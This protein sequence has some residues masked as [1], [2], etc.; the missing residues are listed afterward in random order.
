MKKI[1]DCET[2]YS[3]AFRK[4]NA[5]YIREYKIQNNGISY[6]R[7]LAC[8]YCYVVVGNVD[9][10]NEVLVA[11]QHEAPC[12]QICVGSATKYLKDHAPY[13]QHTGSATCALCKPRPCPRCNGSKTVS[14]EV[15]GFYYGAPIKIPATTGCT[16]CKATGQI[17]GFQD[18]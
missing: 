3:R 11:D 6:N 14:C 13:L 1:K 4:E 12:G 16:R 15:A 8:P 18:E 9:A 17:Q 7:R 2:S 5:A 10:N